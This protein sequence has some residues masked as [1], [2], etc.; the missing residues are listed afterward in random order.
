MRRGWESG[1]TPASELPV[2]EAFLKAAVG[3]NMTSIRIQVRWQVRNLDWNPEIYAY[4]LPGY[5]EWTEWQNVDEQPIKIPLGAE[6][7]QWRQVSNG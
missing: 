4:T 5:L 1:D 2:P 6:Y 7:V 3:A